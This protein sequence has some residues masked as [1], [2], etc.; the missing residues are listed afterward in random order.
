MKDFLNTLRV[1]LFSF[2]IVGLGSALYGQNVAITD[3]DGYSAHASAMLDVKSINKGFLVPRLTTTQR[4]AIDPVATGLLVFDTTEGK[5][6]F[7]N[8]SAWVNNAAEGLWSRSSTNLYLG[9]SGDKVGI[10]TSSPLHK[11]HVY[12]AVSVFDGTDGNFIDIQNPTNGYGIMSGIRFQNGTSVNSFKGGIFYNDRLNWG[13]G[14]I[15]FANNPV[16]ASGNVTLGDARMVIK[17][18]GYV[19]IIGTTTAAVDDPLFEV[20]NKDGEIV[21]GVY[22]EGVRINVSDSDTK[23][24]KGG[25]AIG[26]INGLKGPTNDYLWVT[27]DSIRMYVDEASQTKGAK[28]GFAVGGFNSLGSKGDPTSLFHLT[29]D[30]YFIGH[31]SGINNVG[32]LYNAFLGYQAGKANVGGEKN[33]YIGYNSGLLNV[34][35][36]NNVFIGHNSGKHN[37]YGDFNVYVGDAAGEH[38]SNG[39]YNTYIGYAAGDST[40]GSSYNVAVGYKAGMS[41]ANWQGGAYLGQRAGRLNTGRGNTFIGNKAGEWASS[42]EYNV[43][44]G[45]ISGT[46]A[47]DDGSYNTGSRNVFIGRQAGNFFGAGNENIYIG[48]KAGENST[49]SDNVFIGMESGLS[50]TSNGKLIIRANGHNLITGDFIS[51]YVNINGNLGIGHTSTPSGRLD[52]R[53][54]EA[55]FWDGSAS[56]SYATGTGELY[57]ENDLEVDGRAYVMTDRASSFAGYF[58]NT[59]GSTNR[60][61]IRIRAGSAT[62]T[63]TNYHL[64]IRDGNNSYKGGLLLVDEELAVYQDSDVRLK[65]NIIDSEIAA[66]DIINDLRVVDFNYKQSMN[67]RHTG[68]IAQEVNEIFPD[69]VVYNEEEDT[70]SVSHGKLIPV[71]NRAIQQQQTMIESLEGQL[72]EQQQIIESMVNR[73][74]KLE[75]RQ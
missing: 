73:I 30:N 22:H 34:N 2:I 12:Q 3:D 14:D 67:A 48:Y 28:G 64:E 24:A 40:G 55:R 16:A 1:M 58:Y 31:E 29:K 39:N 11:L 60:Y 33:V 47:P 49:G 51:D 5:F 72:A 38:K 69:M 37:T 71:L 36:S 56:I 66:M 8:G 43:A 4:N 74:E 57:V 65:S 62:G 63:G 18:E 54:N 21:L 59:G 70:W 26:G 9:N 68:Y 61:G 17:N 6:Y 45:S 52:V 23:G 27:P 32:G 75:V 50:N 19:E 44:I 25:F 41:L 10:G 46:R 7:Y 13:R 15:V 42:G 20:K 35:A 53:G